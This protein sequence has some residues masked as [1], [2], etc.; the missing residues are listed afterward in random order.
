[1]IF[2]ILFILSSSLLFL[3]GLLQA[4]YFM[5]K[6]LYSERNI[7]RAMKDFYSYLINYTTIHGISVKLVDTPGESFNANRDATFTLGTFCYLIGETSKTLYQNS[8]EIHLKKSDDLP[9][10]I[11]VLAHEC[12]HHKAV[13]SNRDD[14]EES[15]WEN[16]FSFLRKMKPWEQYILYPYLQS[17]DYTS[18]YKSFKKPS[19]ISS[20]ISYA[21]TPRRG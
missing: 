16:A 4:Y 9:L 17:L 3:M 6:P 5:V 14:S 20:L 13:V 11:A 7:G 12:G 10:Q 18:T 19:L 15:A 2:L 1:M 8:M 21:F